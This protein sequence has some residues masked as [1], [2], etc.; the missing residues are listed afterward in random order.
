MLAFRHPGPLSEQLRCLEFGADRTRAALNVSVP[1]CLRRSEG[2]QRQRSCFFRRRFLSPPLEF[3][4]DSSLAWFH[5]RVLAVAESLPGNPFWTFDRC[6]F[7]EPWQKRT[8]LL[9]TLNL[10]GG[11]ECCL[12]GHSHL[13]LRIEELRAAHLQRQCGSHFRYWSG[14]ENQH[15][16]CQSGV[17]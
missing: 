8:R 1:Q 7:N 11:R 12:G 6:R 3:R 16:V 10:A 5:P 4:C 9:T 13:N 2:C 15:S 17:R 14:L